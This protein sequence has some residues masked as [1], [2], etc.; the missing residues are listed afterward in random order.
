MVGSRWWVFVAAI[1][2]LIAVSI[3]AMGSHSLPDKLK[4]TGISELEVNKKINQC[5]IGVR[6]QIYHSLAI[7]ALALSPSASL[8]RSWR[9][10]SFLFLL[11]IVLFSGGL[12]SM[13]FLN[14]I[15]H[16]SIVPTGGG[17]L[18]AGWIAIAIGSLFP[19]KSIQSTGGSAS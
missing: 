11:G 17:L 8:R 16:W 15:G 4:K 1:S 6:Y 14:T 3:G 9:V 12:Y 18:M 7:L 2:G 5:E 13:V 19:N 10:A